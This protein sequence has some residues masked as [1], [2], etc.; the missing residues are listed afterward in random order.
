[1][2]HGL[3][4]SFHARSPLAAS[5]PIHISFSLHTTA[6]LWNAYARP[7]GNS[8]ALLIPLEAHAYLSAHSI[9]FTAMRKLASWVTILIL[10]VILVLLIVILN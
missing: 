4:Q 10:I 6:E 3:T 7:G 9:C 1:M 5:F 2:Y 8:F